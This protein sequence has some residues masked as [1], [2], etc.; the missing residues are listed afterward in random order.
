MSDTATTASALGRRFVEA[1]AIKDA[2][3]LRAVLHP[4]V[5]FRGLTPNR[6]WEAHD[7]DAVLEIVFGVWFGADDELEELVLMHSDAF[8][9]REQVR[10]RFRGRNRDGPMVVEQQA[11]LTERDG[12]IG[13]MRVV[14]SGQRP[15]A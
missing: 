7:R 8:A 2:E 11:Y 15:L 4:E 9:D 14:C 12:L 3:A 6:F 10:F 1:L 5:D 13:W